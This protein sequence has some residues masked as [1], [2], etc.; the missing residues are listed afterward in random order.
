MDGSQPQLQGWIFGYLPRVRIKIQYGFLISQGTCRGI[1]SDGWMQE[2]HKIGREVA[3]HFRFPL[4][5]LYS[6][7]AVDRLV[8]SSVI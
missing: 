3:A 2:V 6:R 1:L 5:F 7:R 8:E 4:D